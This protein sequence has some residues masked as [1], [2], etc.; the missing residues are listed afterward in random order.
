MEKSCFW[1]VM[2]S[3]GMPE[4]TSET[5]NSDSGVSYAQMIDR[6][7]ARLSSDHSWEAGGY[8]SPEW[9][10]VT[11]PV[12]QVVPKLLEWYSHVKTSHILYVQNVQI[13]G[14]SLP[15]PYII[16]LVDTD[17]GMKAVLLNGT[18][19]GT[20]PYRWYWRVF[21]EWSWP[22]YEGKT[23]KTHVYESK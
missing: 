15:N 1:R 14:S 4:R 9:M 17:E 21:G 23:V 16:A 13:Q 10:G 12:R 5:T 19:L 8:S 2:A 3:C 7:A 6:L 18:R 22:H 20:P 11:N